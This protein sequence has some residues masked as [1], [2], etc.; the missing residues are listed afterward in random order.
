MAVHCSLQIVCV[1]MHDQHSRIATH[2]F[3]SSVDCED[4]MYEVLYAGSSVVG[5]LCTRLT[6]MWQCTRVIKRTCVVTA[7]TASSAAV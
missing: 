2:S 3:E 1:Y 5:R 6:T 4:I 7:A